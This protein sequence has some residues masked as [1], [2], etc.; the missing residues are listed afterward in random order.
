[1]LIQYSDGTNV[2]SGNVFVEK[3]SAID[4]LF[5][6]DE[7][8]IDI[9]LTTDNNVTSA[10]TAWNSMKLVIDISTKKFVST[11]IN[12]TKVDISGFNLMVT[13]AISTK[14]IQTF[15]GVIGATITGSVATAYFDNYIF[16]EDE[17]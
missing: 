7:N 13:P 6:I 8:G 9:L 15:F 11:I 2:Y 10:I 4:E 1:M 3:E 14:F 12:G 17:T 5:L 16:T